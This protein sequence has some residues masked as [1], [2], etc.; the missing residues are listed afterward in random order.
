MKDAAAPR[1]LGIKLIEG[2][3]GEAFVTGEENVT[4]LLVPVLQGD[5]FAADF[6]WSDRTQ[7][8]TIQWPSGAAFPEMVF[9][10]P[11]SNTPIETSPPLA[12]EPFCGCLKARSQ[13]AACTRSLL[14]PSADCARTYGKDCD[15]LLACAEGDPEVLP[16][17]PEG[18]ANAGTTGRCFALCSAEKPCAEGTCTEWQGGR[19]CM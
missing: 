6:T 18:Q 10:K 15:K 3:H 5:H 12:L 13:E 7:R 16:A 1:P 14:T 9:Q 17:C 8:F 2:G 11:S 4:V 19:V